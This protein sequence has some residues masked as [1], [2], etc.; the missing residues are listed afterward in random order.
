MPREDPAKGP[1]PPGD[2]LGIPDIR[3]ANQNLPISDV[4]G[5]LGIREGPH[6][7]FHCWHGENHK[8]GDRTPSVG[9]RKPNNT[10][11]CFGC[12]SKPKS[13]LDVVM[14]VRGCGIP[15]GVAWLDTAFSIPRIPK[16]K[17]LE[18][19][20]QLRPSRIG[21]EDATGLLVQSGIW[22][23]LS[24]SAQRIAPVLLA[25]MD[26]DER[27]GDTFPLRISYR[28]ITKYSGVK[29]QNAIRAAL[30]E[31]VGYEWII[32]QGATPK[33][34]ALLRE[35][36]TYSV[37]PFSDG[38]M[39]IANTLSLQQRETVAAEREVRRVQRNAR[40]AELR[41]R[42]PS[43]RNQEP[44]L[45]GRAGSTKYESLYPSNSVVQKNG[46]LEVASKPFRVPN[47]DKFD[48]LPA[49]SAAAGGGGKW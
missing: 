24:V 12:G 23:A 19:E 29:S 34:G 37:T 28:A 13:V 49:T 36:G 26:R 46:S 35:T 3:W 7:K 44:K 20:R 31:L 9:I 6:G 2:G 10:A 14:D 25:F 21:M 41:S 30:D 33:P 4:L 27:R 38:L 47:A 45:S 17:R 8:N 48:R 1:S 18:N 15:D 16:R 40:T 5:E 22:A 11:K 39:E 32:K 43:N 42:S